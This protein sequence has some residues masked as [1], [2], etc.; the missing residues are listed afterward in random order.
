MHKENKMLEVK[1][2]Y[3]SLSRQLGKLDLKDGQ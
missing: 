3:K 2:V 1:T